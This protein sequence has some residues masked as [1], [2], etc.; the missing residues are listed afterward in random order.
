MV[1]DSERGKHPQGGG[2]GGK[3]ELQIDA[4][5]VH[6]DALPLFL[7]NPAIGG[8]AKQEG[9]KKDEHGPHFV[10]LAAE[11][12]ARKPMSELVDNLHENHDTPDDEEILPTEDVGHSAGEVAGIAGQ[13]PTAHR[14]HRQ[15]HGDGFPRPKKGQ[16]LA[17]SQ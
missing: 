9:G 13:Q 4:S 15:E 8:V 6:H 14:H 10:D 5:E 16:S 2:D 7:E 17:H 12:F 3:E 1:E 11:M